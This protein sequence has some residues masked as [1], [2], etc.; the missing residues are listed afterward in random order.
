MADMETNED[1]QQWAQRS[2][3]LL[4]NRLIRLLNAGVRL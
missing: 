3:T 4:I 2:V 1:L